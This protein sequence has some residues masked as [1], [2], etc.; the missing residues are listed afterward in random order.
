MH[1]LAEQGPVMTVVKLRTLGGPV[2]ARETAGFIAQ[3]EEP[4]IALGVLYRSRPA[5]RI[6]PVT[7][8]CG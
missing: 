6:T 8:G 5:E 3:A 7:R 2:T 1:G 4:G